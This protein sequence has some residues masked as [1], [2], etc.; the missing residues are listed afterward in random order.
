MKPRLILFLSFYVLICW[1]GL[2]SAESLPYESR[3]DS[4]YH[5][6]VYDSAIVY[7]NEAIRADNSQAI[8]WY[9]LGNAHYRLHHIGEAVLA[10]ERALSRK[11]S[12]GQA[13][14]N[15]ALI[16]QQILPASHKDDLLIISIWQRITTPAHSNTYAI[17]AFIFIALPFLLLAYARFNKLKFGWL[18]PQ[19]IAAF[20]ILGVGFC[21]LGC[22]SALR[23]KPN[24]IGVV[25]R[26]DAAFQA[27][28]KG[29]NKMALVN[30]PEGL[31]VKI[32]NKKSDSVRILLPDGREGIL[33][34]SDIVLIE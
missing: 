14:N 9:K 8:L 2:S 34:R 27:E 24:D 1:P 30:L 23:N 25:M 3:G 15:V 17:L 32:L 22:I 19:L 12:F 26:Q 31:V 4:A 7:Y 16:Q 21:V 13:A 18:K 10:Y 5:H 11:P 20:V 29:I 28:A 33:Q 6:R